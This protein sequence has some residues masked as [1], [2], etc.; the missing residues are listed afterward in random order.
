MRIVI[1]IQLPEADDAPV[2]CGAVALRGDVL[3]LSSGRLHEPEAAQCSHGQDS[4]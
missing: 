3:D 1:L 2:A 4:F